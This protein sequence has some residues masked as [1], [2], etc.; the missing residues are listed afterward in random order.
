[1]PL[2]Y[3]HLVILADLQML[4]REETRKIA[5]RNIQNGL[6]RNYSHVSWCMQEEDEFQII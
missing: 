6:T 5:L 1:M 4:T 2:G 3:K